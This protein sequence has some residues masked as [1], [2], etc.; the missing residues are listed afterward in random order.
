MRTETI[1]SMLA[2]GLGAAAQKV[3][4]APKVKCSARPFN[5]PRVDKP[6]TAE[7]FLAYEAFTNSA[8]LYGKVESL[9]GGFAPVPDFVN[10]HAAA[11]DRSY[12]TT[13]EPAKYDPEIC[14]KICNGISGCASFNIYYERVPEIVNPET[15]TPD[16]KVCP[17]LADSPSVTLMRCAFFSAAL[18]AS[19]AINFGSF[20]GDFQLVFAGSNLYAKEPTPETNPGPDIEWF[21]GPVPFGNA[22]IKARGGYLG[23][24][25]FPT[26]KYE[27]EKC[28]EKCT[29]L[30]RWDQDTGEVKY[31]CIFFNAYMLLRNGKDASLH[32]AYYANPF[33]GIRDAT[34]N[35]YVDVD[36]AKYTVRQ[37]HG[38]YL[39][40][41]KWL[42]DNVYGEE[43]D[44]D[45]KPVDGGKADKVETGKE[46]K[47]DKEKKVEEYNAD[48]VGKKNEEAPKKKNQDKVEDKKEKEEKKEEKKEDKKEVKEKNEE[49]KEDKK[50]EEKKQEEVKEEVKEDKKAEDKMEEPKEEKMEEKKEESGGKKKETKEERK[51]R[52]EREREVKKCKKK[53]EV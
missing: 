16:P 14:A 8:L 41:E 39:P 20:Q 48:M 19:S 40:P 38:Y 32:C 47:V 29:R 17:G 33:L 7:A 12:I 13:T 43:D 3:P 22:A 5:G 49:V 50:E 35:G 2:F 18:D 4:A 53:P 36:G 11:E 37:S 9:T 45:R 15:L 27:P 30:F 6:D 26:S 46:E 25:I 42:P 1:I 31:Q 51:A 28:A 34:N 21:Y 52:K 10:L 23:M 24:E 44:R